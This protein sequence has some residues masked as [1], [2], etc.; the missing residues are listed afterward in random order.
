M[1]YIKTDYFWYTI[2]VLVGWIQASADKFTM[3][4]CVY[5]F[6]VCFKVCYYDEKNFKLFAIQDHIHTREIFGSN[7]QVGQN[8]KL[9]S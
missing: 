4:V 9:L 7:L 1:K 3:T 5:V 2:A 6:E 8:V